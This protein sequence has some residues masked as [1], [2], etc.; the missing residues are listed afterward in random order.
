LSAIKQPQRSHAHEV[1]DSLGSKQIPLPSHPCPPPTVG[2]P[3][4]LQ[5]FAVTVRPLL[6][7]IAFMM[8]GSA[9]VTV[10]LQLPE[11][12]LESERYTASSPLSQWGSP[13]TLSDI[14]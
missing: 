13:P 8:F 12:P 2:A 4:L 5:K 6:S 11:S 7:R 3:P 9:F 10:A 1:S 14:A